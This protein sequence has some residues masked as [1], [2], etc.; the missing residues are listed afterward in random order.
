ML[1]RS[2]E[3]SYDRRVVYDTL[4]KLYNAGRVGKKKVHGV[5]SYSATAPEIVAQEFQDKYEGLVLKFDE[6]KSRKTSDLD[7][8]MLKGPNAIRTLVR[9]AQD[10]KSEILLLGRGGRLIE[11]LRDAKYQFV[12]KM[13]ELDWKMIQTKEYS[14]KEFAPK[15]LKIINK[16]FS[17]AFLTF[18]NKVYLF[19]AADEIEVIE[20]VNQEFA[21]TFSTYFN[22]IWQSI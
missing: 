14:N 21:E 7:V 20:I 19:S 1:F 17:T 22:V 5:E 9:N 6:L 15:Q 13:A 18:G 8:N 12:S 16:D 4:D 11:Q 2:K 10:E 3:L